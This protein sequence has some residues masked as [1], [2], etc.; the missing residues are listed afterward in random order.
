MSVTGRAEHL[1]QQQLTKGQIQRQSPGRPYK[2]PLMPPET[3]QRALNNGDR[4]YKSSSSPTKKIIVP[5]SRMPVS[6]TVF[7]LSRIHQVKE[8]YGQHKAYPDG[9]TADARDRKL[10]NL[11]LVGNIVLSGIDGPA[12]NNGGDYTGN[13]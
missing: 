3:A 12:A 1:K 11:T 13:S 8:P 5:P 2:T 7:E 9:D 6:E 4:L 10:V